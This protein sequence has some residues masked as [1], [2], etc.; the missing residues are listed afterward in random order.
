MDDLRSEIRAAF[1]REQAGNAP[2]NAMRSD[3]VDAV[4]AHGR[5]SRNFQWVAAVAAILLAILVVAGLMSTRFAPRASVPAATPKPSSP[6]GEYG[7]P[8]PGVN[9]LYARDPE[10]PTWLIS[11]DWSGNPQGTI[12]LDPAIGAS[13]WRPTGKSLRSGM[14]Q[15]AGPVSS[16]TD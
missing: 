8:P 11:Y 1:E 2:A 16:S 3:I 10:H 5:P 15:K 14:A 4:T 12:K 6:I 7:P 9:L 13:G